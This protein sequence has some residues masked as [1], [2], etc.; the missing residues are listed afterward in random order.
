MFKSND[1]FIKR[2]KLR[3]VLFFQCQ[4][5]LLSLLHET[6]CK[7]EPTKKINFDM[8]EEEKKNAGAFLI[9]L[10]NRIVNV[11]LFFLYS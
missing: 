10:F 1:L 5:L 3:M 2:S 9:L 6:T 11:S 7:R 8:L 4:S